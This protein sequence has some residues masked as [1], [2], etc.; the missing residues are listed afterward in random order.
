MNF[1]QILAIV[2]ARRKVAFFTLLVVVLLTTLVSLVM[3]KQYVASSSVVLDI[4]PDPVGGIVPGAGSPGYLATQMDIIQSD[5][6]STRVVRLLRLGQNPE[7][8]ENWKD[9]T[10]G[11]IPLENYYGQLLARGLGIKP[12]RGSNVINLT[13]TAS[14]PEFAAAVANA[15]AQ[16]Y[17]DVNVELRVEPA[18]QYASWFDE[19]MKTLRGDLEKAQ[20]RLSAYQREKGIVATD[21]SVDNETAKLA[22]LS[23]QLVEAQGQRADTAS[24]LKNTGSELSP[25]VM[26]NPV[27]QALKAEVAKSEARRNELSSTLGKNHPQYRQLEA[28]I[29][30]LNQQLGEEIRRISGSAAT[31]TRVT[32]QKEEEI[33]QAIQAQKEHVLK[34]RAERDTIA[35]L[36]KDV[37]SAQRAYDAVAQRTSLTSLESQ[38]QQNNA[39]ILSPAIAPD[40]PARPRILL[41]FLASIVAGALLG[42]AVAMGLE[43]M[44]KRVRHPSDLAVVEGIP[45][46]GML[47][48]ESKRYSFREHVA[49]WMSYLRRKR[50]PPPPP[51]SEP[52]IANATPGG[53]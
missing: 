48:A 43:K 14:D 53:A 2:W 46:I 35:L 16:A 47:Q 40:E 23:A 24:R 12:S 11:K 51:P 44:D 28:Q 39:S 21:D 13:F 50:R 25:D 6:V 36:A 34:L 3:P 49:T 4:K 20:A 45:V 38:M 30:G 17:V 19:R 10:D 52:G 41:N 8:V 15:Y 5:R 31:A 1:Q 37:E 42:A 18:R 32:S 29:A 7:A 26:E 27:V 33:R 22:A 9:A